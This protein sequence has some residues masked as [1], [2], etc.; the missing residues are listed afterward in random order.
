MSRRNTSRRP[1][2]Q[3]PEN[4]DVRKDIL[5]RSGY[6]FRVVPWAY[7]VKHKDDLI[8]ADFRMVRGSANEGLAW[9]W[10]LALKIAATHKRAGR[11]LPTLRVAGS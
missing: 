1:R 9:A 6:Q 10:E 11:R 3:F 4:F 8:A 5:I 7:I 2:D